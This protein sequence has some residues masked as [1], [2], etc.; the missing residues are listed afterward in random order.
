MWW[1]PRS[2]P[3]SGFHPPATKNGKKWRRKM[4]RWQLRAAEPS[5]VSLG[6]I[7]VLSRDDRP[8][9]FLREALFRRSSVFSVK[10]RLFGMS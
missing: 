9:L 3:P 6:P 8:C 10:T 2:P 5:Y 7:V 4:E 1:L